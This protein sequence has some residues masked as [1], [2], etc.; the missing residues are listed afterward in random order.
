MGWTSA[1][2]AHPTMSAQPHPC[3][4]PLVRVPRPLRF[5]ELSTEAQC[6]FTWCVNLSPQSPPPGRPPSGRLEVNRVLCDLVLPLHGGLRAP[7]HHVF[8]CVCQFTSVYE[9]VCAHAHLCGECVRVC[10]GALPICPTQAGSGSL[11]VP[12]SE[13]AL[14]TRSGPHPP[15]PC[16]EEPGPPGPPTARMLWGQPPR[17]ELGVGR[18]GLAAGGGVRQGEQEGQGLEEAL[19]ERR[20]VLR[21]R[22]RGCQPGSVAWRGDSESGRGRSRGA[23]CGGRSPWPPP[24]LCPTGPPARLCRPRRLPGR[25]GPSDQMVQQEPPAW[26]A[27]QDEGGHCQLA[28]AGHPQS[29][30]FRTSR[31]GVAATLLLSSASPFTRLPARSTSSQAHFRSRRRRG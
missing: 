16:P 25:P 22:D 2:P 13:P 20:Q 11:T 19:R 15:G 6:G 1:L 3:A 10:I 7:E 27:P 4:S 5:E 28:L 31:E 14:G 29:W 30:G 21:W 26:P 9:C 23:A 12:A 8:L 24:P 18:G 17:G